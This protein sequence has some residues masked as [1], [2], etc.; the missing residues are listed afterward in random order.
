MVKFPL[1]SICYKPMMGSYEDRSDDEYS[2]IGDKGEISFIDYQRDQSV[3]SYDLNEDDPVVVSVPFAFV[4]GKPRSVFV[5]E[6]AA[7]SISITNNTDDQI[8][9]W[10]IKIYASTPENSFTLSMMEPVSENSGVNA[11]QGFLESFSLED[12]VLQP[13]ET[14][15]VW[16]SCKP[17]E[18]GLYTSVVHIDVGDDKI[19]RVVFLLVDNKISRSLVS[20][21]PYARGTR[22]KHFDVDKYV[23]GSRPARIATG[24]FKRKLPQYPIPK[25]VR[26]LIEN[27]QIPDAIRG[28]LTREN[29]A[30]FFKTL[31][32]MEE[33]K[34]EVR[35]SSSCIFG[36]RCKKKAKLML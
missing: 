16:L 15:T 24:R 4:D 1:H 17:K 34:L 11:I 9:I 8:D 10:S 33:L 28:G 31:L 21:K 7:D 35:F 19:E 36:I 18:I 13:G 29:Y 32:N 14:L 27:K 2:V 26:E 3:C 30:P 12:R 6:T 22:K 5:G 23:V 25:D 20:K